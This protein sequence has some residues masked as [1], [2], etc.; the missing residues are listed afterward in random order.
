MVAGDLITKNTSP[1][2]NEFSNGMWDEMTFLLHTSVFLIRTAL[3]RTDLGRISSKLLPPESEP[4]YLFSMNAPIEYY[5][6][7]L[8]RSR[9]KIPR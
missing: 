7:R 6:F 2:G 8:N 9:W 1:W 3:A 4:D 5:F